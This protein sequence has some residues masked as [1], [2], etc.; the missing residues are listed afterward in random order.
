MNKLIFNLAF[1]FLVFSTAGIAMPL[2]DSPTRVEKFAMNDGGS[3]TVQT[4]GGSIKVKSHEANELIV[5]MY[6][7]KG[8]S[9]LLG[10]DADKV[11]EQYEVIIEKNGDHVEAIAKRTGSG[12][13][14]NSPSVAFVV[15]TPRDISCELNTSGGSINLDGVRGIQNLKTSGG[16]LTMVDIIGDMEAK[17]SG[18][19][20]KV[21]NYQGMVKAH[22]SGGSIRVEGADGTLE[23]KTSGGSIKLEDIQGMVAAHTSGGGITAN[24]TRLEGQLE[25]KTS[26]GSINATIPDGLGVDL[27]LK[28]STVNTK[29]NN[30]SG[31]SERSKIVGTI[32]GGGIPV[33]LATSGGSVNLKFM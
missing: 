29:L 6:V 11:L 8:G 15:Y 7:R 4:S 9:L 14:W 2:A 27:D 1:T 3:L 32:N 19:S 31:T 13:G 26:G 5:E 16:S 28:G 22:T 24:V 12:W 18:G 33:R 20:I 25:L 21:I 17:T 23:L 30:F 10:H